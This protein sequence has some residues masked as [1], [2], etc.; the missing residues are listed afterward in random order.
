MT[1]FATIWKII[2]SF[3]AIRNKSAATNEPALIL[4][5]GST[6]STGWSRQF[7]FEILSVEGEGVTLRE[8]EVVGLG[9][10]SLPRQLH[11]LYA[12]MDGS[13]PELS[14]LF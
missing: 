9:R 4:I 3:C 10:F 12:L 8:I 14:R 11:V 1:D 7:G 2:W 13:M 6:A 5:R